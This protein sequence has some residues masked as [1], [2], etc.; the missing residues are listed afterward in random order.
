MRV[1]YVNTDEPGLARRRCGRGFV[2]VYPSGALVRSASVKRRIADL[3]VPPAWE[4][5]WLCRDAAGHIQA[6]GRDARRRKQ[7]IYH[8]HWRALRERTK[9]DQLAAFGDALPR[10]RERVERDLRATAPDEAAVLA[11][12]VRVLDRTGIRPGSLSYFHANGSIG[13]TTLRDRHVAINGAR[14]ALEFSAKGGKH[15][16]LSL[17]DRKLAKLLLKCEELPGQRLFRYRC[18]DD[19]RELDSA[20]LNAYLREIADASI[21]AKDFRTWIATVRVVEAW[22]ECES[23]ALASS[24]AARLAAAELGNTPA[25]ARRSYI[26]PEILRIATERA[27]TPGERRTAGRDGNGQSGPERLCRCLLGDL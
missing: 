27:P 10:L 13:L 24:E 16:T 26:H 21:T 25:I 22:L 2:Y 23:G 12:A 4:G 7:Y 11:A 6:M 19:V 17:H 18:G 20:T 8:P 9:F 3:V 14:V 5:V 15:A 1:R